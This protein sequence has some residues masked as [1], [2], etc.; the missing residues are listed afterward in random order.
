MLISLNTCA[1]STA[2]ST[3]LLLEGR[4]HYTKLAGRWF[5][6]METV[7]YVLQYVVDQLGK[8]GSLS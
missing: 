3:L 2:T 4:L 8:E 5:V 7:F 6:L 1:R